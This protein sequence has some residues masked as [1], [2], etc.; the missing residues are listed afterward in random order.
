M[1]S[2]AHELLA[3]SQAELV[4]AL[5]AQGPVP[6]G[7]DEKRVRAAAGSLVS[8][9]RQAIA[10]AWP[11]LAAILG[12]AYVGL[13]ALYGHAQ[14]LPGGGNPLADGR[15]FLRWLDA[16]QPLPDAARAEALAFDIHY[17]VTPRGLRI[18]HG[19]ALQWATL[20]ESKSILIAARV[21]WLGERWWR[22][23]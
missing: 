13:F 9:R 21:P 4:R 12:D 23:P 22:I 8:K 1:T 16:R 11:K 6:A 20:T 19:F 3:K 7:F 10:R 18:R 2:T 5:M 14:S 17:A 15:E